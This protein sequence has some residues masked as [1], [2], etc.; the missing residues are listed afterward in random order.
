MHLFVATPC[1]GG[2]VTKEYML[3]MMELNTALAQ[4]NISVTISMLGNESLIT[5]ARNTLVGQ[6]LDNPDLTHLLFIDA[7][8]KFSAEAVFRLLAHGGPVVAAACPKKNIAWHTMY[9]HRQHCRSAEDLKS[10]AVEFALVSHEQEEVF[11]HESFDGQIVNGFLRT[12]YV[13]TAFMLIARGVFG[14]MRDAYPDNH[15]VVDTPDATAG[16]SRTY[17]SFF[18]TLIHPVT[19]R[20]LSEDYAFC[21]RW[22][23][24]RGEIWVDVESELGHEGAF[25]FEGKP[26]RIV[27]MF[28]DCGSPS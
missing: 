24:C 3:S 2:L 22:R 9:E 28:N 25:L 16:D 14:V 1:Y 21:H 20:Y 12:A 18:E 23:G 4:A 15:Y 11:E 27:E 6:F 17:D 26:Q 13:G 10:L 19:K 8:I 5:R 7:D